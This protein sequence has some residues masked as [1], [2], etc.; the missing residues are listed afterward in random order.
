MTARMPAEFEA[1][2]RTIMCWPARDEIW[3]AA[4]SQAEEDYATIAAA[5]ATF[6]PVT[7]VASE[8]SVDRASDLCGPGVAVV[9]LPI[10]DSW[11]RDSGPIYVIGS[12]GNRLALDWTFNAWGRKFLPYDDDARLVERWCA[13]VDEPRRVVDMVLEGGSLTVDGEGTLI[14]TEQCLLHPN[15]NPDLDRAQIQQ[16]LCEELGVTTVIWLPVGLELDEDTDGHVDNVAAFT[17]PGRVLAQ[18]C[19]D[20]LRA[21]EER[22][23]ANLSVLRDGVD[24]RGRRLDVVEVPVL[25]FIE[26][27]GEVV[28]VPYLN[29]YVC[30]GGVVVPVCGHPADDEMLGL[31]AAEFPG[32]EVVA[33]PGATLALGGGGPHCI[34]QQVPA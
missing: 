33:V 23:A 14:T 4:K 21:D 19:S 8:A 20:P 16:R 25:P 13:M 28:A 11:A 31:I 18:G 9:A 6:E 22:M 3:G 12:D 30:N 7:M 24:A 29:L 1:H 17:A 5:I 26:I 32:R 10:D 15:R 2:E 27:D 34:T